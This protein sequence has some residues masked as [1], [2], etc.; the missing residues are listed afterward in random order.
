LGINVRF[1]PK[2]TE[3]LHSSEMTRWAKKVALMA[4][5]LPV[6]WAQMTKPHTDISSQ[7]KRSIFNIAGICASFPL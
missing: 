4:K 1:G 2:A 7:C 5:Q 6:Q 3:L